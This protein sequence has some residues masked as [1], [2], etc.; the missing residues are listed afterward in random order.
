MPK[1][2]LQLP[3][4]LL[5]EYFST[6]LSLNYVCHENVDVTLNTQEVCSRISGL[7]QIYI[8]GGHRCTDTQKNCLKNFACLSLSLPAYATTWSI[9]LC[10]TFRSTL[11][12]FSNRKHIIRQS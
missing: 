10:S 3:R 1:K 2:R 12:G 9:T 7:Q 5:T 11:H 4:E 6:S 8:L